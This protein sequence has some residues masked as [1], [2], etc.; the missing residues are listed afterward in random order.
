MLTAFVLVTLN[1]FLPRA[2]PGDPIAALADPRSPTYVGDSSTRSAVERYYG[3]ERPLLT[4]YWH[5]LTGL[6]HGD[7]GTSIQYDAPV[8]RILGE[9]LPWTLLLVGT[10]W[11]IGTALGILAGIHSGWRHGRRVDAGLL[12]LVLTVYN[13]PTFFLASIGAYVF[14]VR[15]GWFPL[16]GA[17][18]PF[19]GSSGALAETGDVA[20]HL[21]LPAAVLALQFAPFQYLIMR[22]G[23]VSELGAP[24]LLL[25]RAKGLRDRLLKYRY[26]GRNALL[27]SVTVAGLQ[28]GSAVTAAIF[29]ETVFAYPGMGRL[30]FSAV[31]QR[32]YPMMQGCFLALTI[33]V[34]TANFLADLAN[35]A[36]DPR[37]T[38]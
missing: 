38:A 5:Y 9:R 21:V 32:D 11:V 35:R 29:I 8:S 24:Y 34:V 30:L 12:T 22:A 33:L 23:M 26:A 14:A 4:Q 15:L 37:T 6:V 27:P 36:L 31:N 10:A 25:G 13:V 19:A 18:T 17:R 28:L 2:L 7:I 1:F 3:L 20:Y 16:A